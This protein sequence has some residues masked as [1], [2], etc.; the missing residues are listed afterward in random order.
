M[1]WSLDNDLRFDTQ[2]GHILAIELRDGTN[3]YN[4]EFDETLI[5]AGQVEIQR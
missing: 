5:G 1:I 3:H 4:P 2:P